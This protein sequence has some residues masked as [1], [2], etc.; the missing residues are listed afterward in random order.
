MYIILPIINMTA[1][2]MQFGSYRDNNLYSASIVA[3]ILDVIFSIKLQ[4]GIGNFQSKKLET[5]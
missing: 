5:V 4:K 1:R 3:K 2:Q